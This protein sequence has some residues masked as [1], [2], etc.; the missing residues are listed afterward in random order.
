VTVF[1]ARD[2]VGGR[3]SSEE[4]A[5]VFVERGAE[6]ISLENTTLIE[7]AA[8]LGVSL[9]P[10][11]TPYGDREPRGGAPT[12]REAVRETFEVLQAAGA[13][14]QLSGNLAEAIRSV[15]GLDPAAVDVLEART[16]VSSA[17]S[18]DTLSTAELQHAFGGV[19]TFETFSVEGG[20]QELAERLAVALAE[21]VRLSSPVE[22][23]RWTAAGVTVAAGGAE[24]EADVCVVAVPASVIGRIVFDP[25]LPAETAAALAAVRYGHAA[26]LFLPLRTP[27]EPSAVLSV[28]ER[29]WTFTGLDPAGEPLPVAGSF[30]G[31]P[32]AVSRLRLESGPEIWI[33]RIRELRPELD[34]GSEPWL[35]ATWDDDPWVGAA[36]SAAT[37]GGELGNPALSAAVGPLRFAGEH[38]AGAWHGT[39]EGALRS[40]LRAAQ[41]V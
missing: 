1:E 9:Y 27:V 41:T 39:M 23:V 25:P 16:E 3:V 28:P 17:I 35:L 8:R 19:G 32:D 24:L 30:V 13:A 31:S 2:R 14:G 6:F 40:G 20:N 5:G 29:F 38:T 21:P 12:T 37:I 22:H 15:K 36:Y 18:A 4:F 11:G 33:A 34:L 7:T 10:K 26:K